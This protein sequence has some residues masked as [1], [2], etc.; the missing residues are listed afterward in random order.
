MQLSAIVWRIITPYLMI[1]GD[2]DKVILLAYDKR[3]TILGRD[4][5]EGGA[6]QHSGTGNER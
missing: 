3:L 6:S 2:E 1:A 4:I 5:T